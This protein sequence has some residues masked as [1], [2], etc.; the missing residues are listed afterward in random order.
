MPTISEIKQL[1]G[2]GRLEDV[3]STVRQLPPG[4]WQAYENDLSLLE[5]QYHRLQKELRL[6]ILPMADA[7]VSRNRLANGLLSLLDDISR[8]GP[9][10]MTPPVTQSS[11][12]TE[13]L[14]ILFLAANPSQSGQLRL[15]E[16]FREIREG[17]RLSNQRD[18]IHLSQRWAVR[19]RDLSRAL[20]EEAPHILH[21]AGHGVL[22]TTQSQPAG[23]AFEPQATGGI[24][25]E[26]NQGRAHVAS[27]EA[28]AGLI[29]LFPLQ[30][31]VLNA[32][33]SEGQADALSEHVPYVIGMDQEV[34]DRTAIEFAVGFYDALGAKPQ[35]DYPFAFKLGRSAI[36]MANL[37]G[38]D[39]PQLREGKPST[40]K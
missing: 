20:L 35:R 40:G 33:Y 7:N 3:F 17:L 22:N 9:A 36:S 28:L 14:R 26:D 1:I 39:I 11:P 12:T 30:C 19:P 37:P 18:H 31:V 38:A 5:G 16:E 25:L 24:V 8:T 21:F 29:A 15:G 34:P 13:T 32:C 4:S 27:A 2:Q 23:I 6:G 10:L